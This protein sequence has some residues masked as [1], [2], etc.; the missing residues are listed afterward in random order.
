MKFSYGYWVN[1]PGVRV[2]GAA[3]LRAFE[4]RRGVYTAFVACEPVTNRGQTLSGP[5][6]TLEFDAPRKDIIGVRAYHFKGGVQKGPD[7]EL[8]IDGGELTVEESEDSVILTNG[9]LKLILTKRPFAMSFYYGNQFLTRS[10]TKQ[11]ACISAPDG[12]YMRDRLE[13]SINELFYGLGERF[14]PFVK[15]GQAVDIWNEDGGASSD[16]AYKNIPFCL[17]SRGYGIFVNDPGQV[18]FEVAS[19]AVSK[20]QFSLPGEILH[21]YIIGG[22]S[23]RSALANYT[24][25]TGKPSPPPYW[26]FGLWLST[27]FTTDYDEGTVTGFINGMD[28]RDIPL[29]VFHFDCFWMKEYEWCNF[30]WDNGMF[31]D[32][33]GMLAR[34]KQ[35]GADPSDPPGL[36]VCVWINP[37]IGQKSPLFD[38]A[39]ERGFLLKKADGSV[40]Q[41]DMWQP[42]MGIVDFTNPNAVKWFQSKL[43]ALA[44][45]GVD[46]FKTDFGERI[47]ADA[48]YYSGGDPVRMHNYYTLLYNKAVY[49]LLAEKRGKSDAVVFAR[50]ATVGSQRY[51][52]HWGGDSFATYASMAESL[53]GGLSLAC[54]GFAFWSHDIGGFEA[55]ATPDLYKRW[56]AFG[57]LST[58][59]R[60]HGS[61]SYRVPWLFDDE[62][63]DALRFFTKLKRALMPYIYAQ[64]IKSCEE[65]IGVMRPM[66]MMYPEDPAS[67]RL[68]LQ[69][70]LG[71]SLLVAPVFH[72]D[73]HCD[74]YLP[75]GRFTHL[76]TGEIREGGRYYS[77][78]VGYC[79][80]PI[81]AAE[82]TVLIMA[83][84]Q[85]G[86]Y[87]VHVYELDSAEAD[88]YSPEGE[89]IARV[90]GKRDKDTISLLFEKFTE[91]LSFKTVLHNVAAE[92]ATLGAGDVLEISREGLHGVSM[93]VP[94]SEKQVLLKLSN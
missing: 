78:S 70:M 23:I 20:N 5:L 55:T 90:S 71:D 66:V 59:S 15:N 45:M 53:R 52:V 46:C 10:D 82:N 26:S 83:G 88:I 33:K 63:V 24:A 1:R 64:S 40:W 50:S 3:D 74:Y 22:G 61:N 2:S 54:S 7:F 67:P 9:K 56:L 37:Y 48:V 86:A 92:R 85:Q 62:S 68:D 76:L 6:L 28:E 11:L 17:S 4:N 32:I 43:A 31:S 51:P 13:I 27:S 18:S 79:D 35:K 89:L 19:E 80:I 38:E 30:T 77:D 60:L 8:N 36:K 47:P 25:L 93:V 73:K 39:M 91:G 44:D 34:I 72:E 16:L 65:G 75:E 84:G 87:D 58:H 21:Y 29:S 42:G 49:E 57:L 81:Y 94:E 14:G 41:W 12:V 69:Y